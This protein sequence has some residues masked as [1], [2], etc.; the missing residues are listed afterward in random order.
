[1]V[2]SPSS[3]STSGPA[4]KYTGPSRLYPKQKETRAGPDS[5]SPVTRNPFTPSL[6]ESKEWEI[7]ART[8]HLSFLRVLTYSQASHF[9]GS[10]NW[11]SGFIPL[12]RLYL[13][14]LQR[15]SLGLA[16]R[17]TP[18][19]QSDPL[20]LANLLRHWQ[21]PRFLTSGIPIRTFHD[22]YGRLHSGVGCSH[23]GFPDF[24]YLDLYRPQAPY[25]LS[26]AQGGSLCPKALGPS[27]PGP[28]GYDRYGQFYS[29]FVYQQARRDPF[30]HLV[31]FNSRTSPLVRG[32]EH[33][34]PSKTYSRL[35]ERD[36][37]PP[38]QPISTEWSLHTKIV[39]R[40]FGLW[41][42]PKVDMFATVSNFH[43]P[44]FMSPIPEP[45]AL[46]VDALSQD[47]QGRSV[48]M[49]PPFPLLKKV[50]QKLPSIQAAE[51]IL[52]APWWPKQS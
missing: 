23:G 1:M 6:P 7:V 3:T 50:I 34:S 49:F 24:G 17:F 46:A 36:C 14:P 18:P 28:P 15:H 30:P 9:M 37:R 21:D 41:G 29:S 5:G 4:Y 11:A 19:H 22:F 33:N 2:N 44:W 13:R 25:Q 45:R 43:L 47:W 10:L 48:Y 16:D 52:I 8:R 51:V 27:A 31:T 38:N 32:S 35:S 26:G 40:I 12:G 39:K 20:V 42:T